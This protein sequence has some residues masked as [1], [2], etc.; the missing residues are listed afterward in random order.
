MIRTRAGCRIATCMLLLASVAAAALTDNEKTAVDQLTAMSAIQF[1]TLQLQAAKGLPSAQALLGVAYL[2]GVRVPQDQRAAFALFT[3]AA[4]KQPVA[5]SN[6]GI[7]YFYG[8][9]VEKNYAEAMK[10]F[11]AASAEGIGSAQFNL[12]TMYHHG[13]GVKQDLAEAS[14]WYEI[15][16][17][18]GELQAQNV[19]AT[20]YEAGTGVVQ[21]RAQALK[22][23]TKAAEGGYTMA[24]YNLGSMYRDANDHKTAMEWFLRAAK[25]GHPASIRSV[26][27]MYLH[28][29]CMKVDYHQAYIWLALVRQ[30]DEWTAKMRETC[31]QH[32]PPDELHQLD[33]T[34]SLEVGASR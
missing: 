5:M 8:M 23:Y 17:L 22:W 12:A 11:R 25:Q 1:Q 18:Q 15:A 2:K 20:F 33:E 3:K 32:L 6:L 26:V 34:A 21:D 10:C 28:G 13:Y 9:G 31:R 7:M 16:A 24:Q 29:H 27:E 19:I 14:K 30:Q 4:K